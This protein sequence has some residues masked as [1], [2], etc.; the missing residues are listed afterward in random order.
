MKLNQIVIPAQQLMVSPD[1]SKGQIRRFHRVE[2][3]GDANETTEHIPHRLSK[4]AAPALKKKS[5]VQ[6]RLK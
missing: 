3:A 2:V 5:C 1:Q 4:V 6:L